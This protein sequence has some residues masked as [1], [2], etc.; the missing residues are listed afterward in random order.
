MMS[1]VM[2]VLMVMDMHSQQ[3]PPAILGRE[4]SPWFYTRLPLESG[5]IATSAAFD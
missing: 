4:G 5:C 1:L 3:T 2:M